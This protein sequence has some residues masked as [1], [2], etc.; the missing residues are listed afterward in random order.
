[1]REVG[2]TQNL[3]K[4]REVKVKVSKKNANKGGGGPHSPK[5]KQTS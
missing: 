1:M 4:E 2:V 3:T 5:I